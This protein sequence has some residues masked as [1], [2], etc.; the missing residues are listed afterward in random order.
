[1]AALSCAVSTA[2]A[3]VL[4][5]AADL[6][7]GTAGNAIN[8]AGIVVGGIITSNG[9]EDAFY[10]VNGQMTVLNVGSL[11]GY[12]AATGINNAGVIV[13]AGYVNPN[14]FAQPYDSFI[15]NN[16]TFTIL[17]TPGG[18]MA[19]QGI[20]NAGTVAGGY[21][22]DYGNLYWDPFTYS[23]G[24]ITSL[25]SFGGA[26]VT[27]GLAI[28]DAGTVVGYYF[29]TPGGSPDYA[30]SYNNGTYTNLGTLPGGGASSANAINNTGNIVGYG[31]TSN[32]N[33]HAFSYNNGTMTDLGTLPGWSNSVATGINNAGTIVGYVSTNSS[34]GANTN[35]HAFIYGNGSMSDLNSDLLHGIGTTLTGAAAVNDLGQIVAEGSNGHAYLLTQIPIYYP[36]LVLNGGFETGDFTSWTLSGDSGNISYDTLVDNGSEGITPY[37]GNYVALLGTSGSL[38][39]LSQTLSTTAGASYLLSF[40]LNNVFNDPNVFMVSW[41]GNTL[42]DTTNFNA[43]NWTN[44]QFMATAA[45]TS[46]VLQFG[47]EDNVNWL[48]LDEVS[49]VPVPG[50]ASFSLSGTNLVINGS[51]GFSGTVYYVLMSTNVSLPLN[52]WTPVAT[53]VL[54]ASGNFTITATNAV[55]LNVPQCFYILQM[56]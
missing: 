21:A 5:S 46:T 50:I 11:Q 14:T 52:Q 3:Q 56:Q 12:T 39:Y 27:Y 38:G 7:S 10:Y 44:L 16:G 49:A 51:N 18:T 45:G 22:L 13:G 43:N 1:M 15:Y 19:A 53:N 48:G 2:N 4:Y 17:S 35:N 9:N 37:S 55:N 23:N 36:N 8:G 30:F 28:N 42:L 20:N 33:N 26:A 24:T 32:G 47:F 34:L 31:S 29:I 41:N 40:W 6:G 25:G 54:N